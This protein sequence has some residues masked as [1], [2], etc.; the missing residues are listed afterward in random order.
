MTITDLL[1]KIRQPYID[2]FSRTAAQADFHVEPLL[3]GPDGSAIYEGNLDTPYRCDLVHKETFKSESVDATESIRFETVCCDIGTMRLN[4]SAFS[5]DR[6]TLSING[7]RQ[8]AAEKVMR[9]WFLHWFDENDSNVANI[10]GLYG[11][12]HFMSDPVSEG[13]AVRFEVDLGSAPAD[14]VAML[15]EKLSDQGASALRLC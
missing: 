2:Q 1:K 14:A 15:I 9:D 4:L 3:R 7:M 6:L 13:T 5:W 11:V 8:P 12:V 10:E